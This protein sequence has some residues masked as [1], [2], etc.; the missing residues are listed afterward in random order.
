MNTISNTFVDTSTTFNEIEK[1]VKPDSKVPS[2][3]ELM[4]L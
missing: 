2:L 4:L 1:V 3:N